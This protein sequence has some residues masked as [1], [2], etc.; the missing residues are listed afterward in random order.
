MQRKRKLTLAKAS[1]IEARCPFCTAD[2]THG[3]PPTGER[4]RIISG[5]RAGKTGVAVE[6]PLDFA[7]LPFEFAAIMDGVPEHAPCRVM[8]RQELIEILPGPFSLCPGDAAQIDSWV[9]DFCDNSLVDPKCEICWPRFFDL[10]AQVW[11]KRLPIKAN[12]PDIEEVPI[13]IR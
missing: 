9:V 2:A 5:I 12:E 8:L 13:C 7:A 11:T 6:P 3:R 1:G 10:V 4:F